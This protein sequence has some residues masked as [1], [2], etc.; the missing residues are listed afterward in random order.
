MP[1][2]IHDSE[3]EEYSPGK[4]GDEGSNSEMDECPPSN[5][6]TRDT[7]ERDII[8][9][10]YEFKTS[11]EWV[12]FLL[13]SF[14]N[15]MTFD[16]LDS[17]PTFQRNVSIQSVI[18]YIYA[19]PYMQRMLTESNIEH[20]KPQ[21]SD[22]ALLSVKSGLV[23]GEKLESL[24]NNMSSDLSSQL[25]WEA[26]KAS[27]KQVIKYF[28]I[29]Y[30]SWRTLTLRQLGIKRNRLLRS[31]HPL[32]VLQLTLPKIDKI[33]YSLQQ[34]L[35]D[36]SALKEGAIWRENDPN[37]ENT[38]TNGPIQMNT[39]VQQYYQML[40]SIDT[41][42]PT[43]IITYLDDIHFDRVLSID[44]TESL[45]TEIFLDELIAQ[46]KRV[47]KSFSP[48]VDGL[49]QAKG[50]DLP[51][52][53]LLLDQEK[54]YDRVYWDYHNDQLHGFTFKGSS[55][56]EESLTASSKLKLPAYAD[57]VRIL[58]R[59]QNDFSR[60]QHHMQRYTLVYN[61]R[62]N[63]DKNEAFSLNEYN[64][65]FVDGLTEYLGTKIGYDA[66]LQNTLNTKKKIFKACGM[67]GAVYLSDAMS[68]S[69]L[70][71]LPKARRGKITEPGVDIYECIQ[72]LDEMKCTQ[73]MYDSK[74]VRSLILY[75]IFSPLLI[76]NFSEAGCVINISKLHRS[77]MRFTLWV[78][79]SVYF[80]IS[81]MKDDI[82]YP[83]VKVKLDK[84]EFRPNTTIIYLGRTTEKP[85]RHEVN[86]TIY[87][88]YGLFVLCSGYEHFGICKLCAY[89]CAYISLSTLK[90]HYG[91]SP[92]FCYLQLV[93]LAMMYV[94]II[95]CLG[96]HTVVKCVL[97]QSLLAVGFS[98]TMS[99]TIAKNCS[100]RNVFTVR[101]TRLKSHYLARMVGV[102][103]AL[104]V[105]PL[106]VWYAI[107]L[108]QVIEYDLSATIFCWLCAFPTA[109]VGS[110]ENF[111]IS[112]LAVGVW[113]FLLVAVSTFLA[114]KLTKPSYSYSLED[115]LNLNV[116][117][118]NLFGF[119]VQAHEGVLPVKKMAHVKKKSKKNATLHSYTEEESHHSFR[120]RTDLGL[121]FLFQVSDREALKRWVKRFK[122]GKAE[123]ATVK[124]DIPV[125][126][127]QL[128]LPKLQSTTFGVGNNPGTTSIT[129]PSMTAHSSFYIPSAFSTSQQVQD[130]SQSALHNPLLSINNLEHNLSGINGSSFGVVES[131]WKRYP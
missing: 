89:G 71:D 93:D 27:T 2:L 69:H 68:G 99:W 30:V 37:V 41:V 88:G 84:F 77:M 51:G 1:F 38:C 61:A 42:E 23:F 9:N 114:F 21:W 8:R 64:F 95:L 73:D 78:Q 12:S 62:F 31:K 14:Y 58:L 128:S 81:Y 119:T 63:I 24:A 85:V 107:F 126:L 40:Y 11:T 5:P 80:D 7:A 22:H 44:D 103:M 120:I 86:L 115:N 4:T 122:G 74:S 118:K 83:Y 92:F 117:A 131:K 75:N 90:T 111:T 104:A 45:E 26:V 66:Q 70:D 124:K 34:E 55:Y 32:I 98:L 79:S 91:A 105:L 52:I 76:E 130:G 72:E 33:I 123:D 109:K 94:D 59:A 56:N 113:C 48:G 57:D 25:K 50:L 101:T 47:K 112:E 82:S 17:V 87:K 39:Y 102:I 20:I 67:N 54:A 29:K 65:V 97:L 19:G 100:F 60:A 125:L 53:G 106:V 28:G 127:D 15:C 46:T 3:D 6:T 35:V 116:V 129:Q 18:D 16:E 110:W 121:V 13:N 96:K 43:E 49:D 36:A 108:M 10:N